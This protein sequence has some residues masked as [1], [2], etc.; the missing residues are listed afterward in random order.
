MLYDIACP[1]HKPPI[2][3]DPRT[4]NPLPSSDL[5]IRASVGFARRVRGSTSKIYKLCIP[6]NTDDNPSDFDVSIIGVLAS[7]MHY[8]GRS[9]E[10]IEPNIDVS[11]EVDTSPL[12]QHLSE[13]RRRR[14]SRENAAAQNFTK[15]ATAY[16][17]YLVLMRLKASGCIP[18]CCRIRMRCEGRTFWTFSPGG[19]NTFGQLGDGTTQSGPRST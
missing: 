2:C 3:I 8:E 1:D 11:F 5:A 13:R 4:G 16:Y 18:R 12:K 17:Y 14:G 10:D 6:A 15:P 9:L 19:R 7:C